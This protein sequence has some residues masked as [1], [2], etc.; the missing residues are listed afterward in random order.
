MSKPSCRRLSVAPLTGVE[1]QGRG[2][3]G[4]GS[5]AVGISHSLPSGSHFIQGTHPF[6]GLLPQFHQGQG[7]GGGDLFSSGERSN[8]AC[9]SPFSGLLQPSFCGDEGFR[10]VEAGDRPFVAEPE[11]SEDVL[12]DGDSPVGHVVCPTWRLDGVFQLERRLLASSDASGIAQ[13]PQVRGVGEGLPVQ[14]SVLWSLHG[15]T[16]L[17]T[18][19]GSGFSLSSSG[20]YSSSSLL[21]RLAHPG[22]LQGAGSSCSGVSSPALQPTGYRRQLG[23]V[24]SGSLSTGGVSGS[25]VRFCDF[26]GFACPK[27]SVE[28]S[29]NWRRVL[30]LRAAASL[31]LAGAVGSA[32][33]IDPAHSRGETSDAVPPVL[34][35]SVLGLFGSVFTDPVGCGLSG[36][37]P[38]VAGSAS[39]GVRS[40]PESDFSTARVVVRRLGCRLGRSSRRRTR[41]RPLVSQRAVAVHQRQRVAG[42]RESSVIFRS[43]SAGLRHRPVRRQFYGHCLP[44]QS[45]GYS[46]EDSEFHCS[47]DSPVGG[48][49]GSHSGSTVHLGLPQRDGGCSVSSQ[50]G[51]G[52]RMVSEDRGLS[53]AQ[54]EV[55]C[56]HRSLRHLSKSSLFTVFLSFPRSE[57]GSHGCFAS[58]LEWVAGV[59]FS[60][61]GPHSCSP[62]E[63]PVIV[64]SPPDVDRSL[65]ASASVVPGASGSGCGRSGDSSSVQGSSQTAPLSSFPSGGVKAVS[66]C[67]ETIQRFAQSQGF[68]RHVARQS[69]LARRPSSR[70]GYQARWAVFRKWCHDKGHS[71]TR[72]SLQKVADF[73]FWLRMSR[74]LSVSA[75]MGYRSMLSA[76]FRSVLPDISSSSVLQDLICSFKVE[77]PPRVVRPPSWDLLCVLTYLR[78]PVFEPLHESSLRDLSRKTL[79]L[80]ALAT[81]KRVGELQAVSRA[82]SFSSSAAGISYVPEFLAKTEPAVRSLPRSFSL[83]SLGVF[84]AG[85][86]EDLLLC[87]VRS[88][89]EYVRRTDALVNHPRR[90]FV[91]PR[92]PSRAMSKNAISYFLREVIV[93]SGAS[94]EEIAAP[95]A[96]SIRGIATSSAFFRN[97]SLASVLD[98]A[99]WRSNS[100]FTSFYFRDM[101]FVMD[102]V[103]ALGPFVTA[104]QRIS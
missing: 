79:F 42:Y 34:S 38:V 32:G 26:Q 35:Q 48:V 57:R 23:E 100:V 101:Q 47:A 95:K 92:C 88:L 77:V 7:L 53:G 69:A 58:G 64:W 94:S 74:K 54:E 60:S 33:F 85:L 97:W 4:G 17:H 62:Q 61:L 6:S 52:L 13:V 41:F 63:A 81:A 36:R 50:S 59:C 45:G 84:A 49:S 75:V 20:G 78:S 14:S 65:L 102:G 24:S 68:S 27:E 28:A 103:Y 43:S 25:S 31:C 11:G 90:L 40:L 19:H 71:V 82:V 67:V 3:L 12:Q 93:Q 30:V 89:R 44:S 70:A 10:V 76:V 1:R 29:L 83:P 16:S 98:A 18:G 96:H 87:P 21:G 15:S 9:S 104:G 80:L 39:S 56:F 37:S 2:S 72:P 46:V 51:V 86:P 8:R 99:S 22:L 5:L 73:L 55:A 66:S 91:A